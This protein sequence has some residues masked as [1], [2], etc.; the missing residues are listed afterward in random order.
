VP[1]QEQMATQID[2][3]ETGAAGDEITQCHRAQ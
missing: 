1:L 3:Q 2:A